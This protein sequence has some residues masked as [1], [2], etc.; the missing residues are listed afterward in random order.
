MHNTKL[1]I[2]VNYTT[3][4]TPH[5]YIPP[6]ALLGRDYNQARDSNTDQFF[7]TVVGL[8]VFAASEK[9]SKLL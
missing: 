7:E 3:I 8:P 2:I 9:D 5:S 4:Q 6:L 1:I